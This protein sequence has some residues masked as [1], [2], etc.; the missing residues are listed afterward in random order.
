MRRVFLDI[1]ILHCP[2][3]TARLYTS[4]TLDMDITKH[5]TRIAC[6]SS[7]LMSAQL[8]AR[9]PC[10][11][12]KWCG[13]SCAYDYYMAYHSCNTS[14]PLNTA[15]PLWRAHNATH[16]SDT[17]ERYVNEWSSSVT[18]AQFIAM[19]PC[20]TWKCSGNAWCLEPNMWSLSNAWPMICTLTN[21]TNRIH[22]ERVPCL[23]LHTQ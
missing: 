7:S 12:W 6:R 18:S 16:P 22:G 20:H 9:A 23:Q 15:K 1:H 4:G 10:Q 3:T 19:P 8:I 13:T 21:L 5:A 2:M 11:T 14:C 17:M